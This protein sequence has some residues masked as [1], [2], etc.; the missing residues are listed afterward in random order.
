M[1][2]LKISKEERKIQFIYLIALWLFLGGLFCYVCFN[3]YDVNEIRSKEMVIAKIDTENSILKSQFESAVRIDSLRK[4]LLQ[5]QPS[6]SQVSLEN[7]IESELKELRDIYESKKADPTY[8]I[9][10][11]LYV[12]YSM[13]F[14]DKKAIWN[15]TN[16]ITNLKKN[17]EDCEIGFKQKQDNLNLKN[18]LSTGDQK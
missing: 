18:A 16:N 17:L 5:Y 13:N 6:T 1:R 15:S 8:K 11:Q 9:F 4:I 10:N 14:F 3:S 2:I 12:F 7:N